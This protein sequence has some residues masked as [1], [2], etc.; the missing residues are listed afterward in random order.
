[1]EDFLCSNLTMY[2]E[3][4]DSTDHT[5]RRLER[6]SSCDKMDCNH[7]SPAYLKEACEFD[8]ALTNDASFAC[9]PSKIDPIIEVPGPND[10][11]PHP[12][13]PVENS[14]ASGDDTTSRLLYENS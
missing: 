14:D 5:M 3:I 2:L 6:D 8:I 1:M 12:L 13:D 7:I 10:F 11:V 9:E 4:T